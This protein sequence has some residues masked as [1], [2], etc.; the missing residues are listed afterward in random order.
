[1][2]HKIAHA[3]AGLGVEETVEEHCEALTQRGRFC[4]RAVSKNGPMAQRQSATASASALQQQVV[5]ERLPV[6]RRIRLHRR[7]G[8]RLG[9]G[10]RE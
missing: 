5:Y 7:V 6:G 1:V 2:S 4:A 9:E 8:E 3:S 10:Y